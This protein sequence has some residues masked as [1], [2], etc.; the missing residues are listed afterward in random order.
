MNFYFLDAG[1]AGLAYFIL[2]IFIGFMILCIL[3]EAVV[4]LVMKYNERFKKTLL[5][6]LLVNLA[7]VAVGFVL[8]ESNF[9]L[10]SR[11]NL[12]N[13]VILYAITVVV[14]A[15]ILYLLNK[16]KPFSNTVLTS[17]IMNIPSYVALYF[18]GNG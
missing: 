16:N 15:G 12:G 13:M 10:F 6:S 7:S 9:G 11:Y 3:I 8:T 5:D 17:V 18:I 14:E 2:G 4:M 1:G